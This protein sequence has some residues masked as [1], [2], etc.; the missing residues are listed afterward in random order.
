MPRIKFNSM[1]TSGELPAKK[2]SL[3]S[4]SKKYIKVTEEADKRINEGQRR[5]AN[6]YQRAE[7]FLAR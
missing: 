5:Y 1:I 6:A 3:T 7:S 4:R 2:A